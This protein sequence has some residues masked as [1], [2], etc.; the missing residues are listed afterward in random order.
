MIVLSVYIVILAY[1]STLFETSENFLKPV[2]IK[3]QAQVSH[4]IIGSNTK[5]PLYVVLTVLHNGKVYGVGLRGGDWKTNTLVT[6]G[7]KIDDKDK[8][9]I[10]AVLREGYEEMGIRVTARHMFLEIREEETCYFYAY[11]PPNETVIIEGPEPEYER[12]ITPTKDCT[13]FIPQMFESAQ[14]VWANK[15]K[16]YSVDINELLSKTDV[17]IGS[18]MER[19]CIQLDWMRSQQRFNV[20]IQ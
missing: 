18:C 14:D 2:I 7:G 19:V 17:W 4:E 16:I 12:E 20:Y 11:V 15:R 10:D 13:V 9:P 8:T 1:L 6:A 5:G 3:M